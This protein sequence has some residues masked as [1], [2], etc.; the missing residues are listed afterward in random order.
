MCKFCNGVC[1][2]H[3]NPPC[4]HCVSHVECAICKQ[5]VCKDKAQSIKDTASCDVLFICPD[6]MEEGVD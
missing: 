3:Q 4:G 5:Q 1:S 6:C 2:C